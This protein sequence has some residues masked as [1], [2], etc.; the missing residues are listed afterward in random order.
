MKQ[1]KSNYFFPFLLI[2]GMIALTFLQTGC[3]KTSLL[4][5]GGEVRFSIDTLSFDT[6]FTT[7]GSFTL[8]LKIYNPQNQKIV[9][10]SVRLEKGAASYFHLN[11]DGFPGV[12]VK[13]IEIAANDSAFVFATVKINPDSADLPFIIEDKLI[14]TLNGKDFSIPVFA[15]GQNA[16][17]IIGEELNTQTWLTDKPYVVV[18]SAQVNPGQTLT[19]PAGCRVFMHADSRLVVYGTL[20]VNGTLH[21]SVVF[22]GDR[23]DRAYFGYEG[24]PGEWGGLYFDTASVNN[25][26][27]HAILKNGGN[28]AL[29]ASPA[30]I[31]VN[32]DRVADARPQLLLDRVTLQNSIGYGLLSFGGTVEAYNCLIHTTGAQAM[33]FIEGGNYKI[34]NCTIVNYGSDKVSHVDNSAAIVLNYRKVSD[35][36]YIVRDL[37]ASIRNCVVYGSLANEL[38]IDTLYQSGLS[39]NIS[40][41]NCLVRAE[42]AK[43][44]STV[45]AVNVNYTQDPLFI[46]TVTEKWNFRAK[47]GSPLI[48]TGVDTTGFD[49]DD[50]P[51]LRG[52]HTD[53][54]AYEEA[55]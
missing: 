11:V 45:N 51:R 6:V 4:S 9:L 24:Y 25:E 10:S 14:A 7:Q 13:D 19:I 44:P 28:N 18:H 37:Q 52:A 23:L 46:N 21:D 20:K 34:N 1:I 41:V 49:L 47:A 53:I 27:H 5:S 12:E 35:N 26:L 15:Y 40:L 54:G 36:E 50:N 30:L 32:P 16:H 48:D 29:G 42:A 2:A 22:Q 39:S 8:S 31:Q 33:A 43:I 55:P 3:K 17:F 38:I